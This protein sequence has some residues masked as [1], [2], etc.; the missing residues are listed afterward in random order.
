MWLWAHH[1]K[2]VVVDQERAFIG[3]L[4]LCFG[5]DDN[6]DH[7]L[8]DVYH[9]KGKAEIEEIKSDVCECHAGCV[10]YGGAGVFYVPCIEMC[11]GLL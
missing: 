8:T 7:E 11:R 10:A 4:D 3:G 9:S 5:R 1:E 2:I 6:R